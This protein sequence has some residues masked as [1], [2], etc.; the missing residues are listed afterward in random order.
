MHASIYGFCICMLLYMHMHGSG[1]HIW[2]SSVYAHIEKSTS[3]TVHLWMLA[4]KNAH[5]WKWDFVYAP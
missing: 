4:S 2:S 1:Y 3:V 5:L